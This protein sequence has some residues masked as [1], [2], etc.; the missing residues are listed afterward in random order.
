[1]RYECVQWT[2]L[3]TDETETTYLIGCLKLIHEGS[4]IMR[5]DVIARRI[6]PGRGEVHFHDDDNG[7]TDRMLLILWLED[8]RIP[9]TIFTN[10]GKDR[11]R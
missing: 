11:D 7:Y 9:A 3:A 2:P 4:E 8:V 1:M 6:G 5:R 10:P